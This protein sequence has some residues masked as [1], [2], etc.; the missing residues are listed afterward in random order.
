MEV[1]VNKEMREVRLSVTIFVHRYSSTT[2]LNRSLFC[3]NAAAM[4]DMTRILYIYWYW[5]ISSTG[6]T[7]M[8]AVL[9]ILEALLPLSVLGS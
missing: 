7:G 4:R 1:R 3:T 9:S 2:N 6:Q 5:C 8:N